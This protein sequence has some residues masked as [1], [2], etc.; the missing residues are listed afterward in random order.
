MISNFPLGVSKQESLCCE[1]M[2][3]F[4]TRQTV[5]SQNT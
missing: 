2:M 1:A 4:H 3:F 5:S